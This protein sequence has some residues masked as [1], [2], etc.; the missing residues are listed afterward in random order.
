[1]ERCP[2]L[3]YEL[4]THRAFLS[5]QRKQLDPQYLHFLL[6][7]IGADDRHPAIEVAA[8]GKF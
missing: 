4:S 8:V 7:G 5:D 3:I 6:P 2:A 1:M